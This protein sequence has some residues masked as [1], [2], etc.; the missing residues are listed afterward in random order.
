MSSSDIRKY[1]DLLQE[2]QNITEQQLTE[3]GFLSKIRNKLVDLLTDKPDAPQPSRDEEEENRAAVD[4]RMKHRAKKI[5]DK[6]VA[7]I[8]ESGVKPTIENVIVWLHKFPSINAMDISI[9]FRNIG[10]DVGN[11]PLALQPIK[12][13]NDKEEKA[14]EGPS[15]TD[16]TKDATKPET[17]S[18]PATEAK[19]EAGKQEA[20]LK[21]VKDEKKDDTKAGKLPVGATFSHTL[22]NQ[23]GTRVL[24]GKVIGPVANDQVPVEWE[25]GSKGSLHATNDLVTVL[26]LPKGDEKPDEETSDVDVAPTGTMFDASGKPLKP[27][28]DVTVLVGSKVRASKSP[29]DRDA[30][31]GK[32]K[33][34][35]PGENYV[36]IDLGNEMLKV[37]ADQIDAGWLHVGKHSK[38]E[39]LDWISKNSPTSEGIELFAFNAILEA[40]FH[41]VGTAADALVEDF[42]G[43]AALM[44]MERSQQVAKMVLSKAKLL[45]LFETLLYIQFAKKRGFSTEDVVPHSISDDFVNEYVDDAFKEVLKKARDMK[46]MKEKEVKASLKKV[47]GE[48]EPQ[49]T[50]ELTPKVMTL[51]R[52]TAK[53]GAGADFA[54]V[55]AFLSV[56]PSLLALKHHQIASEFVGYVLDHIQTN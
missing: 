23:H 43:M 24:K 1:I 47:W 16:A 44:L 37:N 54:V 10:V 27:G 20:K 15:A 50:D 49:L 30:V 39:M 53:H 55:T 21:A 35:Y 41:T 6:F 28:I 17:K 7:E 25:S 36:L 12:E 3:A 4:A 56:L 11:L 26:E 51:M 38:E 40:R 5:Y 32:V 19:P 29:A 13:L 46:D 2:K 45:T 33:G 48:V 8:T 18:E 9:G 14:A 22:T 52:W 34:C 42:V 31:A